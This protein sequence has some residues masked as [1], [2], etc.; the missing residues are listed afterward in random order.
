MWYVDLQS[1]LLTREWYP[2]KP[3]LSSTSDDTGFMKSSWEMGLRATKPPLVLTGNKKTGS[4]EYLYANFQNATSY[5]YYTR[6]WHY[7]QG[8]SCTVGQE[9]ARQNVLGKRGC[10]HLLEHWSRFL[11][12]TK[13]C[14][15]YSAHRSLYSFI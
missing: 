2:W 12:V 14:N 7:T 3:S 4:Q 10:I 6:A 13:E 8:G 15:K 9:W 11:Q 1:T 5:T